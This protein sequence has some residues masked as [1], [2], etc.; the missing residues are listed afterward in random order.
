VLQSLQEVRV[1]RMAGRR[2]QPKLNDIERVRLLEMTRVLRDALAGI[3]VGQ[4]IHL[5]GERRNHPGYAE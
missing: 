5:Q 2:P 3:D 1:Q 4:H